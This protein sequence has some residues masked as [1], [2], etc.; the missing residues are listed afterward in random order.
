MMAVR[1]AVSEAFALDD[2]DKLDEFGSLASW[3]SLDELDEFDTRVCRVVLGLLTPSTVVLIVK[4]CELPM[5][6][7]L[8]LAAAVTPAQISTSST[9]SLPSSDHGTSVISTQSD[10]SNLSQSNWKLA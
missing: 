7:S 3:T 6:C 4:L 8:Q 10:H 1:D 9:E 5:Y 2:L